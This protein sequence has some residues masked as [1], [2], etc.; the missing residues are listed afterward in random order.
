[1]VMWLRFR[2]W[3]FRP[4]SE[5][6]VYRRLLR[7]ARRA[8]VTGGDLVLVQTP[9]DLSRTPRLQ[10]IREECN[11]EGLSL[12][13]AAD[14]VDRLKVVLGVQFP[15]GWRRS[16]GNRKSYPAVDAAVKAATREAEAASA[17]PG[18]LESA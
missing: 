7:L 13:Q 11:A 18:G 1:M 8:G 6:R 15:L 12:E 5:E 14:V 2:W 16:V 17:S 4:P 9:M 10:F 3:D